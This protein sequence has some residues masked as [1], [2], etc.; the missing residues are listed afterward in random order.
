MASV[1]PRRE[2]KFWSACFKIPTGKIDAK[3]R[4]IFRR[5]QRSTGTTDRSRAEQLAISYERVAVLAAEKQFTE[6]A[7]RKFLQE[8]TAI[9]GVTIGNVE[10][11]DAY[12]KRWLTNRGPTLEESSRSRY[13]GVVNHFIAWLGPRAQAPL[14]EISPQTIARYRDAETAAGKRPVTVNKTLNI[15]AQAFAEP[16]QFK[17]FDTNPAKGLNVRGAGRQKQKRVPFTFDQ[18][19][20]LVK[21][22]AA[23]DPAEVPHPPGRRAYT[24][25]ARDPV[26]VVAG[27]WLSLI[28]VCAY[29]GARQQEA[30]QLGWEQVDVA[31]SR[32]TL[33][34]TKT[35]D[36]HWI[37][38]HP[39]LQAHLRRLARRVHGKRTPAGP[40]MPTLARTQRR[41]LSNIFRR[42][43]L[44]LIGIVQDYAENP[45]SRRQLAPYSIHSLRHSLSTWLQQAGVEEMM[46]MQIVGHEDESVNRGYTHSDFKARSAAL[47][48]VPSI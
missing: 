4:I 19:K 21:A 44:P 39:S 12:L 7:A 8:I 46:R 24:Q 32:L 17:V 36:E 47:A 23:F 30:A 22:L 31:K 41:I 34:R 26:G 16:T 15:L 40:I 1:R 20:A 18:F 35:G 25:T 45:G 5:V 14:L 6:N 48:R 38:M 29:T 27:D 11:T 2:S 13:E 43:I 28:V 9:S 42:S 10:A 33:N 3:G 37:P